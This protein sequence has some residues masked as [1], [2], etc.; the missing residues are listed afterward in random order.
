[1]KRLHSILVCITLL[2]LIL[3]T[4]ASLNVAQKTD[5]I[6]GHLLY[7][8]RTDDGVTQY[9]HRSGDEHTT[10]E[11]AEDQCY[12]ISQSRRYLSLAIPEEEAIQIYDLWTGEMILEVEPDATWD[13]CFLGWT[14][15]DRLII[16]QKADPRQITL[17]DIETGNVVEPEA[18]TVPTSTLPDELPRLA[19]GAMALRSISREIVVYDQCLPKVDSEV[20]GELTCLGDSQIVIYSIPEQQ[21]IHI[22]EDTNRSIFGDQFALFASLSPSGRYLFYATTGPDALS[23]YRLYDV[24]AEQYLDLSNIPDI[25]LD[26]FKGFRWSP[27]EQRMTLA[28]HEERFVSEFSRRIAVLDISSG[29]F[30]ILN[31]IYEVQ[32]GND[33]VWS[34]ASDALALVEADGTLSI[35]D[36]L[37]N[38]SF[39]LD[40]GVSSVV[41][42]KS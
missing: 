10:F 40:E 32:G 9:I 11:V 7:V 35:I 36:V 3:L 31:D 16:P 39:V 18:Y 27:D 34:P 15:D 26:H 6:P 23:P 25:S 12:N 4:T 5:E 13:L 1:M 22:L 17:L 33:W 41:A 20:L 19:P 2:T 28:L 21:I 42:W 38:T 24:V 37:S 14:I 8:K 29:D 30:T